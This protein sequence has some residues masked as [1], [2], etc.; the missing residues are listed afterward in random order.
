MLPIREVIL[1]VA[2]ASLR[3]ALAEFW[4]DAG[5]RTHAFATARGGRRR[6]AL[7]KGPALVVV[8][9]RAPG[10]TALLTALRASPALRRMPVVAI[11]PR[12]RRVPGAFAT[13]TRPRDLSAW[14]AIYERLR[15]R[16]DGAAAE[17]VAVRPAA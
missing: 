11:V 1:I 8:D 3:E 17:L 14:L 5:C 4:R 7:A 13:V 9:T 15:R 6:L 16:N 10:A 12:A 2:R